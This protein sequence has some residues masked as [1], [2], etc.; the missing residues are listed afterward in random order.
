MGLVA[1]LAYAVLWSRHTVDDLTV[2]HPY[3]DWL[4]E[5]AASIQAAA[6]GVTSDEA[7]SNHPWQSAWTVTLDP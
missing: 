2:N 7:M 3:R 6:P 5:I 1:M 4:D